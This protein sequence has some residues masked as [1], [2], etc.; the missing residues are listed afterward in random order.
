M[1]CGG[2]GGDPAGDFSSPQRLQ[3]VIEAEQSALAADRKSHGAGVS[4]GQFADVVSFEDF[5]DALSL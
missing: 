5:A 3:V 2:D 1:W 4:E